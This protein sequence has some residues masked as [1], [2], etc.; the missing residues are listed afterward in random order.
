MNPYISCA[1]AALLGLAF[2]IILKVRSLSNTAEKANLEFSFV[3]FMKTDALVNITALIVIGIT[4]IVID[5][6][7]VSDPDSIVKIGPL[8]INYVSFSFVFIGY[9]GTDVLSRL[10]SR[11]GKKYIEVIDHKTTIADNAT[12]NLDTPTKI[13]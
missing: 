2:Q 12:G 4:M 5:P 10:F 7:S 8:K 3:K 1:L 6:N 13:A 11:M 9:A